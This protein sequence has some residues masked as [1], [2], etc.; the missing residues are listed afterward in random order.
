MLGIQLARYVCEA[1]GYMEEWVD[2]EDIPR[3][4]QKYPTMY[5]IEGQ[6]KAARLSFF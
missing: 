6:E 2:K 4:N 3:L 1:C 5:N